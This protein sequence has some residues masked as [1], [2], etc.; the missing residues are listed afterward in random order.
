MHASRGVSGNARHATA[1]N[2]GM[3]FSRE[4]WNFW[5]RSHHGTERVCI[6]MSLLMRR[7]SHDYFWSDCG[8]RWDLRDFPEFFQLSLGNVC[9]LEL[10]VSACAVVCLVFATRMAEAWSVD[11]CYLLLIGVTGRRK[12]E[13]WVITSREA[14]SAIFS[15]W[16]KM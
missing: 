12:Y 7:A 6:C 5:D 8:C 3:R 14:L 2:N 15:L 4:N 16:V 10:F 1:G 9:V 11:L 13:F